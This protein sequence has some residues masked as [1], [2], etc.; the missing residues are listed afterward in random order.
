M[1]NAKR[2]DYPN[3]PALSFK[4]C[5]WYLAGDV[6]PLLLYL[7]EKFSDTRDAPTCYRNPDRK[8]PCDHVLYCF[9][10]RNQPR[11]L[12]LHLTDELDWGFLYIDRETI[13]PELYSEI[14]NRFNLKNLKTVFVVSGAGS[15]H[16]K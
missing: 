14:V 15:K 10:S 16:V 2:V 6:R 3:R 5:M 1:L 9:K 7:H 8:C 13:C 11:V 12:S 4:A